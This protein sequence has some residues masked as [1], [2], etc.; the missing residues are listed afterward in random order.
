M[1][2][3][4][5]AAF[6]WGLAPNG[7]LGAIKMLNYTSAQLPGISTTCYGILTQ[8]VNCDPVLLDIAQI[9]I[10]NEYYHPDAVLTAL[11]TSTC[12]NAL[13]IWLRRVQ[14]QCAT[15]WIQMRGVNVSPLLYSQTYAEAYNHTCVKNSAGA[16]CNAVARSAAKID[17]TDQVQTATPDAN[18]RCNSCYISLKATQA[19]MPLAS[20]TA[21][22]DLVGNL[23]SSCSVTIPP[24]TTPVLPTFVSRGSN[25]VTT[26]TVPAAPTC[27]GTTYTIASGNTCQ[28]IS[29]SQE[30]ST[31]NL[32]RANNLQSFCSNFPTSGSLCIPTA[33]KCTPHTVL[34]NQ[35]CGSI[36]AS[37]N[38]S[39][40]RFISWNPDLGA[41]C[42]NIADYVGYVICKSNPGGGWV[43]PT[44]FPTTTVET[45]S[46]VDTRPWISMNALTTEITLSHSPSF[47]TNITDLR[48]TA[49]PVAPGTRQDCFSYLDPPIRLPIQIVNGEATNRTYSSQCSAVAAGYNITLAELK[50]WNPSLGPANSTADCTMSPALRYCV[51]PIEQRVNGTSACI[52][53]ELA[54]PGYT[55]REFS[56][57]WGLDFKGQ[58]RAW[59]PSVQDDCTGFRTGKDYCI[60]VYKYRQPGQI[61]TCNKWVMANTTNFYDKPC[62]IIETKFGMNHNRFVA[63]NP[64]VLSNCTQIY[65]KYEYCVSI[66]NFTPI[67]TT[68]SSETE[69]LFMAAAT[70]F[71][72]TSTSSPVTTTS[73]RSSTATSATTSASTSVGKGNKKRQ[74]HVTALHPELVK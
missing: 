5:V 72:T 6:L 10:D 25:T 35:T 58:F 43:D 37:I 52:Q 41:D 39:W 8:D 60:A 14:Q 47:T 42:Q 67:Y 56:S 9:G 66:P 62:Q 45:T 48:P 50:D 15:Q 22:R 3:G 33:M 44:P 61:A 31:S 19:Q 26:S 11:C 17:P 29:T 68:V 59:N 49:M 27:A 21:V 23:T 4:I 30:I 13:T 51:R 12:T 40:T 70:I 57:S 71:P 54:K 38:V 24:L 1:R 65:P 7:V 53:Y 74:A 46:T 18:W 69:D 20:N 63:W 34:A 28:S 64:A 32:L 36:A 73:S 55:C 16:F 2:S